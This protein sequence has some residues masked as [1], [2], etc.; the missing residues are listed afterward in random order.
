MLMA[1]HDL[2]S[3][4]SNPNEADLNTK[5]KYKHLYVQLKCSLRP[6]GHSITIK[7][8]FDDWRSN[9]N[10]I[11]QT[12][13]NKFEFLSH[14]KDSEWLLLANGTIIDR[15]NAAQFG[16]ILSAQIPPLAILEIAFIV[17]S[18]VSLDAL[19]KKQS[20]MPPLN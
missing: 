17:T 7:L 9:L 20:N 15:N 2:L 11:L 10:F 8:P 19:V 16:E 14:M 1:Q 12:I 13:R 5:N 6:P 4:T 3:T 18:N